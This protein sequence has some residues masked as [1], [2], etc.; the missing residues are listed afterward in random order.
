MGLLVGGIGVYLVISVA[1]TVCA[2]QR[3]VAESPS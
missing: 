3:L 2:G 1:P